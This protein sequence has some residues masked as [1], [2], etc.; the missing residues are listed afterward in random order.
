MTFISKYKRDFQITVL[1]VLCPASL[2]IQRGLSLLWFQ[3]K[4]KGNSWF[5]LYSEVYHYYDFKERLSEI[6]DFPY[7]Y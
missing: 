3:E 6:L 4:V 1:K 5:S 2:Y 7:D